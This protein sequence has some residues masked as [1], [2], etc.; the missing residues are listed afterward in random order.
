MTIGVQTAHHFCA[1][2]AGALALWMARPK[3]P[4]QVDYGRLADQLQAVVE[5]LRA[6][7]AE[8]R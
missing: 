7:A 2:A 5:I 8:K 6:K 1:E 3:D 4:P